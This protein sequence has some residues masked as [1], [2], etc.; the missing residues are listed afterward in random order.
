MGKQRKPFDDQIAQKAIEYDNEHNGGVT[1]FI[2]GAMFA[3]E[4]DPWF[5]PEKDGEPS[6]LLGAYIIYTEERNYLSATTE[7]VNDRNGFIDE[8]GGIY[9]YDDVRCYMP[10]P[11]PKDK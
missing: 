7:D 11:K 3:R 2:D 8:Q 10:I 5:Y 1:A 4:I 9:G 6:V